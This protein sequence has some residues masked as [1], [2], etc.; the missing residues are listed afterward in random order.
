MFEFCVR[1]LEHV[2]ESD[3]PDQHEFIVKHFES[4]RY[5]ELQIE[6]DGEMSDKRERLSGEFVQECRNSLKMIFFQDDPPSLHDIK[7][8][9]FYAI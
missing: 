5:N 2:L 6:I 7:D 3:L 8:P 4:N 1:G 9:E